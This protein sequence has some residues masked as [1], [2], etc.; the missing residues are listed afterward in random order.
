MSLFWNETTC[1]L[2]TLTMKLAPLDKDGLDLVFTVGQE[3]PFNAKGKN[4]HKEFRKRMDWA[5]PSANSS[6]SAERKTNMTETLGRVFSEY[7]SQNKRKRMTLL[8][9]TDGQWRGMP[10]RTAVGKKIADFINSS[11]V[12]RHKMEDRRFSIS[13]IQF[14]DDPYVSKLLKWL[15]DQWSTLY[16]LP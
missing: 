7:I 14:G 3:K 15:D 5:A 4:A 11:F 6:A 16:D 13:F 12:Q 10:E 8:V 2:E 1:V 9:L